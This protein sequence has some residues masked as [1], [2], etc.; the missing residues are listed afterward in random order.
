[1]I[2]NR[3]YK[4]NEKTRLEVISACWID[5]EVMLQFINVFSQ[6][7]YLFLILGVMITKAQGLIRCSL[8]N[9]QERTIISFHPEFV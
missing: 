8:D 4:K 6:K 7:V 2:A 9:H 5:S 3:K 1:V